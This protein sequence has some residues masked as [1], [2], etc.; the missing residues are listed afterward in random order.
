MTFPDRVAARASEIRPARAVLSVLAFP[1]YLLGLFIG[2][3]LA[4]VLWA[5]AAVQVGIADVR[6][7]ADESG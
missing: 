4:V 3:A 5:V 2:L 6:A 1:F 7:R